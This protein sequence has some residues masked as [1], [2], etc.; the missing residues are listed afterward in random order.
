MRMA[1]IFCLRSRVRWTRHEDKPVVH[2]TYSPCRIQ[3]VVYWLCGNDTSRRA[4]FL[5][6]DPVTGCHTLNHGFGLDDTTL[7]R[8]MTG[9][10]HRLTVIVV[11]VVSHVQLIN[12]RR[13][14]P[15]SGPDR[16]QQVVL[17]TGLLA[18]SG[19]LH[20]YMRLAR[21]TYSL[22]LVCRRSHNTSIDRCIPRSS[23][24]LLYDDRR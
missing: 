17:M 24:S 6:T 19:P 23:S 15:A 7:E 13:T 4:C 1:Y 5:G 9:K 21:Q 11:L 12:L 10:T 14:S 2:G 16:T 3:R 20:H 18:A 22:V 8:R